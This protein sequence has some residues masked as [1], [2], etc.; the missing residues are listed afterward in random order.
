[1]KSECK[2]ESNVNWSVFKKKLGVFVVLS[3]SFL[4]QLQAQC[5]EELIYPKIYFRSV[6]MPL[7]GLKVDQAVVRSISGD[8]SG[9]IRSI[10]STDLQKDLYV[11]LSED[12][13]QFACDS[14]VVELVLPCYQRFDSLSME[15]GRNIEID[16]KVLQCS[17]KFN[18]DLCLHERKVNFISSTYVS[19]T[20]VN[21]KVV[22]YVY[23]KNSSLLLKQESWDLS[24]CKENRSNE[25]QPPTPQEEDVQRMVFEELSDKVN[26]LLFPWTE[27]VGIL[28]MDDRSFGI[29]EAY[30]LLQEGDIDIAFAKS[31]LILK[32]C[33]NSP[34]VGKRSLAHAYYNVGVLYLVK[35]DFEKA[36]EN[37]SE[38][39][40]I[41]PCTSVTYAI[42][43]CERERVKKNQLS[44]FYH[45]GQ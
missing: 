12:N 33:I 9:Q 36:L 2:L 23:D 35:G 21:L 10:L 30:K 14:S 39:K 31:K 22:V 42:S 3:L 15:G 38:A 29:K 13:T 28:F 44:G 19:K 34:K 4:L 11:R 17:T 18:S 5:V 25:R 8:C 37:L 20:T 27:N 1:M 32:N 6:Q 45:L 7:L 26:R 16:L 24:S 41:R 43:L 40:R